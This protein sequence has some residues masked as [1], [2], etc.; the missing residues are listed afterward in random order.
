[1]AVQADKIVDVV[2]FLRD[3]PAAGSS[4]LST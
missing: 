1:V 4:A 3:D 2:R